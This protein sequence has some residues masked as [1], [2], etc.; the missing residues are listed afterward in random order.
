[1]PADFAVGQTA[2]VIIAIAV[3]IQSLL[4]II[5]AWLVVRA[6][7]DMTVKLERQ[8]ELLLARAD[9]VT[10]AT[11]QLAGTIERC[12]N[13]TSTLLHHGERLA[14][15]VAAGVATPKALLIAGAASKLITSWRGRRRP[16]VSSPASHPSLPSRQLSVPSEIS[17]MACRAPAQERHASGLVHP[18]VSHSGAPSGPR[19]SDHE[20]S[21]KRADQRHHQ[22]H[23]RQEMNETV[24][25]HGRG[26]SEAPDEKE[27][28]KEGPQHDALRRM[29]DRLGRA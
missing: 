27:C 16:P 17:K 12:V 23:E 2:L 26:K 6:W 1:M 10:D 5:G 8:L 28:D 3:S 20:P 9:Q 21:L 11:Q 4:L 18:R 15:V 24:D 25:S 22:S 29:H 14:S 19:E 7:N 13:R